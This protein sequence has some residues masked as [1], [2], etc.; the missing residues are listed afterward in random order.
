[1]DL[2]EKMKELGG[3]WEYAGGRYLAELTSGKVSDKFLN[4]GV[5][6]C[7]PKSLSYAVQHLIHKPVPDGVEDVDTFAVRYS[8]KENTYVC[9]P[10][11]GGVTLA[12]E[13]ARQLGGTAVFTEPVYKTVTTFDMEGDDY[14]RTVKDGQALKRFMIPEG[15]TVLFVEDVITTG[16]STL[17]M[18]SAVRDATEANFLPYVLCIINR[19]GLPS[20]GRH[21]KKDQAPDYYTGEITNV[22]AHQE[23]KVI[24]LADIE[25]RTWN[26]I[27]EAE[28]AITGRMPSGKYTVPGT[29]T[30]INMAPMEAVR[31]KDN[32][33][34]LTG[35]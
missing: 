15:A 35:E 6:T 5:V 14:P 17:E 16:K 19:S 28:K 29:G 13:V 34:L 32:W 11:M 3:Y 26:T 2:I 7:R 22:L 8:Y 9:G 33:A 31:P 4:T 10:A 20:I 25:A 21:V 23:F 18:I 30:V 27:E 1:M 24:S 12:Y